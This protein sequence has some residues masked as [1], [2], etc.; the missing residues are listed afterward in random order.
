[1]IRSSKLLI[2]DEGKQPCIFL[3]KHFGLKLSFSNVR[4]WYA[5]ERLLHV[6]DLTE[7]ALD[8]DTDAIIQNTLRQELGA[9]VTVLTIAHRLQTIVDAD[10][11]VSLLRFPPDH[12]KT[13][14]GNIDG[15]RRRSYRQYPF[16]VGS[17]SPDLNF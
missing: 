10:S 11:I 17:T 16:F 13:N 4:D 8:H 1:M 15:A 12:G 3:V 14:F 9:D 7:N 2:L 5:S 6:T